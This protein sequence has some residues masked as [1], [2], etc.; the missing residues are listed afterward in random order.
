M[1]ATPFLPNPEA[2][3]GSATVMDGQLRTLQE[4][5][6]VVLVSFIGADPTD[7]DAVAEIRRR[8]IEAHVV[9]R[10]VSTGL[11]AVA[12]RGRLALH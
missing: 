6:E 8:G 11:R 3:F 2:S 4:R 1:M 5:H 10:S 7:A 9:R 12:R